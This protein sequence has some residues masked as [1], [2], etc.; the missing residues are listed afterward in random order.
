MSAQNAPNTLT[1]PTA[2]I[3]T[4]LDRT[5]IYSRA[6]SP[7]SLFDTADP[8]C[9]ELYDGKPLSYMTAAAVRALT[10]LAA[11]VPTVP[12]TTRT[13]EQYRRI[14]LP[15]APFPYAVVSNGGRI[16]VDGGDDPEW[17]HGVESRIRDGSA[18]L[19]AVHAEL[20]RRIDSEWVR[21]LRIA[22][23]LFCYLVVDRDLQPGDF[24]A[25][26][27]DWCRP[28]GWT[29]SQQGRKIYT[30]P[31]SV[32]KSSAVAEVHRR[33]VGRGVLARGAPILAAGDGRL[34]AD[35][36]EAATAGIR[37]RHGELEELGWHAEGVAVT[38]S[39]GIVAADEILAWFTAKSRAAG[40]APPTRGR[41]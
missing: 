8:V 34:D 38:D 40:A 33:L 16:L 30:M 39:S 4:D 31:V 25:G 2:L 19:A 3:A 18:P 22:D 15:G 11:A 14:R 5:L 29:V 12:V 7:A 37:P 23:E 32:T 36:L 28:H 9:V 20:Q 41:T 13:A 35:L 26:W 24:L 10:G 1:A 17:R 6:S 21:S 27:Q